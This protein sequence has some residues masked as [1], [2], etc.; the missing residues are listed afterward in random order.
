MKRCENCEQL[1]DGMFRDCYQC[2]D[3]GT[4]VE[5]E[6]RAMD[7]EV[8]RLTA[9]RNQA[10]HDR[11]EYEKGMAEIHSQLSEAHQMLS[12]YADKTNWIQGRYEGGI[13]FTVAEDDKGQKARDILAKHNEQV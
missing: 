1:H 11:W 9:E 8:A 7:G 13:F 4:E 3:C 10:R 5:Y 6:Q 2:H 12:W